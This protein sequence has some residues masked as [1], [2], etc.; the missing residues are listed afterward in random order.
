[1][2]IAETLVTVV[3]VYLGAGVLVAVVF[4]LW[5]VDRSHTEARGSYLFRLLVAPGVV[6]L[7]PL[8]LWRWRVPAPPDGPRATPEEG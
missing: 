5:G 1:M 3:E 4:L 8:V 2:A 6:G 7:W